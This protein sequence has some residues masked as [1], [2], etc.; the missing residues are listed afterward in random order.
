MTFW[1]A[2]G[3]MTLA[4]VAAVVLPILRSRAV[5]RRAADYDIEVYRDQLKEVERNKTRNLIGDEE[6]EAAKAEIGRRILEADQRRQKAASEGASTSRATVRVA[7]VLIAVA[8]PA[9]AVTLYLSEGRPDLEGQ[10]FASRNLPEDAGTRL[11]G[12]GG[13]GMGQQAQSGSPAQGGGQSGQGQ[14]LAQAADNLAAKLEQNP[15]NV[16]QWVLLGRTRLAMQRYDAAVEAFEQAAQR[17]PE[18][19]EVNAY[20]GEALVMANRGT[21]VPK[22]QDAFRKVRAQVPDDPRSRFYLGLA[23]KQAGNPQAALEMWKQLAADAE[24]GAPYLQALSQQMAQVERELDIE[25]GTTFAEVKPEAPAAD[26]GGQSART[27]ASDGQAGSASN[28][29]APNPSREQVEAAQN[30]SAEDRQQ[31]IQGM[32]DRLA[33]RLEENPQDAQGWQRLIRSYGVLGRNAEATQA[34]ADALAV[35][36][37]NARVRQQLKLAAQQQG[38]AM[39]EGVSPP[40][41]TASE[42]SGQS[43]GQP[44]GG[45]AGMP[46]GGQQGQLSA[47]QRQRMLEQ[48]AEGLSNQLQNNPDD[49]SGWTRLGQTYLQLGEMEKAIDA[50]A[51]AEQ[52]A[53]EDPAVLLTYARALRQDAG[54]QTEQTVQLTRRALEQVPDNPEA[55][56]FGAMAELREGDKDE[57]RAM[58]DKAIDQLPPDTPQTAELRKRADQ[59]LADN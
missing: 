51:N 5:A 58:F 36:Q 57:A 30:M 23:E 10:P 14:S 44:S 52:R 41:R 13:N 18:R 29:N 6:A 24:P 1:I 9:G 3:L 22:A 38:V 40:E 56:W 17:A 42:G 26:A 50:L 27:G 55:L 8:V 28:G 43:G 37:G 39:P 20:Y 12:R 7:A 46:S 35:F 25:P 19:A 11:S 31:M 15:D 54:T 34:L 53:P 33:S 48:I 32:V 49:V 16:D 4:V 45:A 21:V 2:A 47:A 59:M